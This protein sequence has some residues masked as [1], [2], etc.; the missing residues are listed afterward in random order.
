MSKYIIGFD[1]SFTRTGICI[2]NLEEKEIEFTTASCKIGEKLFE[3]VVHAAQSITNQLKESLSKYG[4]DY[5]IVMESPL[6]MSSMSSALY[7]LGTLIYHTFYDHIKHTYNPA[8]LR[9]K[10]HG[11]KYDK[12]DSQNLAYKY[13]NIL[14]KSGYIIKSVMGTK[15]LVCHDCC[16]AFLYAWLYLHDLKHPDFLF[17]NSEEIAKYK[18]RMKNLKKKEKEL[19]SQ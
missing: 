14:E 9:S 1:P 18:E 3:N 16:E 4:N 19:M 7:S 15:R 17:D 12:K 11:H 10:I 5:V 13:L 8:T 2:I 6:P